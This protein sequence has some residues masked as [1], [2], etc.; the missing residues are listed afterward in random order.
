MTN[1]D[2]IKLLFMPT[3]EV[4]VLTL[5]FF[6]DVVGVILVEVVGVGFELVENLA[7]LNVVSTLTVT[8]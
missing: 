6:V 2:T 3:S 1:T 5:G 7:T 8:E 4:R